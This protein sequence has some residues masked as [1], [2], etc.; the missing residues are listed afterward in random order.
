MNAALK[1]KMF[2]QSKTPKYLSVFVSVF[3]NYFVF[4]FLMQFYFNIITTKYVNFKQ[5]KLSSSM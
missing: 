5:K 2:V 4:V 1:S 3:Y